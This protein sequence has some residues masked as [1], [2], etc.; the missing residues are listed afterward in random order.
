MEIM[1]YLHRI[2]EQNV[3]CVQTDGATLKKPSQSSAKELSNTLGYTPV[4]CRFAEIINSTLFEIPRSKL[5]R[6][7]VKQRF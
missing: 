6:T 4:P 7:V 1:A 2:V 5:G 3:R